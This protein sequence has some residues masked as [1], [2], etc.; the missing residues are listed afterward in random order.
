MRIPLLILGIVVI[1]AGVVGFSSVFT[2]RQDE[3]VLVLQFG[4]PLRTVTEPGLHFKVPLL[5]NV[6]TFDKRVLDFDAETEEVP[7]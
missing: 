6:A 7:T 1:V 2:V 5:Q 4:E 3:Q